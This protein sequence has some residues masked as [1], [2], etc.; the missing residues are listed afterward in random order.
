MMWS[1]FQKFE[2]EI[3]VEGDGKEGLVIDVRNN[4]GG[5]TADH[6]LTFLFLLFMQQ[7]YLEEEVLATPEIGE[8]MLRTKPIVVLCNKKFQ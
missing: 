7:Q 5:F 4:G 3:Y 1:E 6:L 2:R 8:C